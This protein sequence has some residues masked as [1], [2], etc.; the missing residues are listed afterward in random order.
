LPALTFALAPASCLVPVSRLVRGLSLCRGRRGDAGLSPG[1]RGGS[2]GTGA[3]DGLPNGAA[4]HGTGVCGGKP[5]AA[6]GPPSAIQVECSGAKLPKTTAAVTPATAADSA[7]ANARR[8]LAMAARSARRPP[9]GLNRGRPARLNKGLL[10]GLNKG[11]P[12]GLKRGRPFGLN[13]GLPFGT[14]PLFRKTPGALSPAG[15]SSHGK[16]GG[17]CVLT[18]LR[19]RPADRLV[20]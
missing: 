18:P 8:S 15:Y 5:P 16:P 13:K 11:L 2:C 17:R 20:I 9:T 3:P 12:A 7:R 1:R 19:W 10:A 14:T 4:D 6:P